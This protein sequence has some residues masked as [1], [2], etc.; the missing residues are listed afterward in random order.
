MVSLIT[1]VVVA[2]I[3]IAIVLVLFE[4]NRSNAFVDWIVGAGDTLTTPFH[5]IFNLDGRKA[6]VAVNWGLAAIAY[7]IVGGFIARLLRR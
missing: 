7:A 6:T 5:G 4:A 1:S 2:L 3:L